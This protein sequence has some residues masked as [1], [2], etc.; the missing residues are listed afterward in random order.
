MRSPF[1]EDQT[2]Q[3]KSDLKID[4]F[5]PKEIELILEMLEEQGFDM[6][7]TRYFGSAKQG[8][9]DFARKQ[10]LK[11][12]FGWQTSMRFLAVG[13][14]Y[15]QREV[16]DCIDYVKAWRLVQKYW[17]VS[18]IKFKPKSAHG[19]NW[20]FFSGRSNLINKTPFLGVHRLGAFPKTFNLNY[21]AW[22]EKLGDEPTYEQREEVL[23]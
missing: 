20:V 3:I 2:D 8:T 5:K 4:G 9:L 21:K 16:N 14:P 1:A 7:C 6:T 12:R 10:W 19:M 11:Q 23:G 17:S 18:Q 22:M 15:I 13:D